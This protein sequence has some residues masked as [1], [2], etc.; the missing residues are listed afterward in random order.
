VPFTG[1]FAGPKAVRAVGAWVRNHGA[2]ITAVYTSNV[3]QY[4]FQQGDDWSRYYKNIAT[5]PLNEMSTFIRS[6]P[7]S[8]VF[9]NQP[10]ARA[11][12]MLCSMTELVS[13]FSAGK[14]QSYAAVAALCRQAER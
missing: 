4:L 2:A 12:S 9:P 8:M 10:G 1:D 3:E 5:L 7:S 11:A 6:I 14:I 13:E